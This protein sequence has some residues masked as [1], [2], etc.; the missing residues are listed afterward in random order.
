MMTKTISETWTNTSRPHAASCRS[1]QPEQRDRRVRWRVKRVRQIAGALCAMVALAIVAVMGYRHFEHARGWVKTNNAYVA[2]HVHNVSS[3]VAGIVEEV[4]VTE[5]QPVAAGRVLARLDS[6]DFEVRRKQA[7]A[8]AAQ[9]HAKLEEAEAQIAQAKAEVT[10]QEAYATRAAHD[11]ERDEALYQNAVGAISRQEY[12]QA[13][14]ECDARRAALR[15]AEAAVTSA[16]AIAAAARAQESVA[17]ANVEAAELQVSYTQIVAPASGRV[18]RKNLEAGNHVQPGQVLVAIVQPEVWVTANF[19]ETQLAHLR[20]GDAARVQL[21]A[22]P[23]K[24]F[25]GHVDGV[26]PASGAQFALL[27]PDNAI[28]NFTR[29]VQ[30]VPVKIVFDHPSPPGCVDEMAPGMSA[31]V[32]VKVHE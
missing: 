4:L 31:T 19:K 8:E 17:L 2:G 13:R 21:D 16:G 18:G 27:P 9:A 5:N 1:I 14:T 3:R 22:F 29:I 30:R 32:E 20:P 6:R 23:G 11:L 26:A 25:S 24:V 10:H 15:G 28:G 7:V 12:D